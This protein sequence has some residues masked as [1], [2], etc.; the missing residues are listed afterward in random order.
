MSWEYQRSKERIEKHLDGMGEIKVEKLVRE[1]DLQTLLSETN[2]REIY[3]AHVYLPVTNFAH[4]ASNGLY[5]QDDYKRLIR[6]VHIYQREVAHIVEDGVIFDGLRVHFQGPKL[7]ALLYRP[8]DDAETLAARAVL[9]Q[10]VL[11]DFVSAVFNPAFPDYDPF[12][13]AGG[14]DLGSVIGTRNGARGDRELLFLGRPANHAAKIISSAGRLRL[15]AD[16]YDC[17]PD[18]VQDICAAVDGEEHIYQVER[19]GQTRLDELLD[20]HGIAWDRDASAKR[21]DEDRRRFPLKDI[22]YSAADV[23]IKLDDLSIRNSKRVLGAS[24]FA[25]VTGFTAYIDAAEDDDE[26]H[27]ALRV[28][29]AIRKEM[30]AVIKGDFDGVRVQYQGDRAQGLFHLPKDDDTAIATTVVEAAVGLQ[31]S[32]ERTLKECLPAASDLRLAVGVDMDTTLA[33]KLGTHGQRDRICLGD[34]VECAAANEERIGGGQIGLSKRV[35]DALPDRLRSYFSYDS[36]ARCYVATDLTTN[37][38]ELAAKALGVYG[39]GK[40]VFV[41]SSQGGV[42]VGAT[43]VAGARAISPSRPY[44]S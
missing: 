26:R 9:L 32:M 14:A 39:V 7:H 25:D 8:I 31:S 38:V 19:V 6:A 36:A 22:A 44:A 13:V 34:P 20:A 23:K 10:L 17:L 12:A 41:R 43:E 29:H 3:G 4:L 11:K 1:A 18:D 27:E 2:C 42:V 33:S 24:L 30:A 15:T 40:S 28:F 35:Y 37:K 5:A 21:V 16:L